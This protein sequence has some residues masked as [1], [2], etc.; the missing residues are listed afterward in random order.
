ML[1]YMY[2]MYTEGHYTKLV[3]IIHHRLVVQVYKFKIPL[4][5]RVFIELNNIKQT[6]ATKCPSTGSDASFSVMRLNVHKAAKQKCDNFRQFVTVVP[7]KSA[8]PRVV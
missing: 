2:Y 3:S 5:P 7:M 1:M 8:M 4:N 6:F